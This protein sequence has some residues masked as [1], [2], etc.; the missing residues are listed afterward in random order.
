MIQPLTI[1]GLKVPNN[2]VLAPM[3]GVTDGP[4]RL[5]CHEQGAGL[6]VSELAS[7]KGI[8]LQTR[9]TLDM[10]R[11]K[12]EPR[13]YAIQIFGSD[14]DMMARAAR[15]V[16]SWQICDM[17]DINMGCPV[18]KVVKTGAGAALMKTPDLA[19]KIVAAVKAAIRLPLT[20]KCRLG[21]SHTSMNLRDFVKGLIDQGAAAITV[22]ARTKEDGYSGSAH[23]HHLENLQALCGPIPLIANGDIHTFQDVK[24]LHE[25]SGCQ[26]FMI[27]RGTVGR[28]WMFR[29]I[30]ETARDA[31]ACR[32]IAF[33]ET[34]P[35]LTNAEKFSIF[36]EHLVETLMEHGG[37]GVYLF[38]VH[39]FNYLKGH[40]HVSQLRQQLCFERSPQTVIEVG[41][42]FFEE[43]FRFG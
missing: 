11:F 1:G 22:H 29:E 12:G 42:R 39:L 25:I 4:F 24:K 15:L 30:L 19:W 41:K 38:R 35:P 14:P 2:L 8:L 31:K 10:I 18:S 32:E 26:G 43:D 21:W 33:P 13:P 7:A 6:T 34:P 17:I 5:I 16:E 37:K 28:P 23:W 27:G 9:Q 3:A 36:R 20:V 40:P